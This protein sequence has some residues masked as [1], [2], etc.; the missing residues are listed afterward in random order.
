MPRESQED[1]IWDTA[2][3]LYRREASGRRGSQLKIWKRAQTSRPAYAF[4]SHT[5]LNKETVWLLLDCTIHCS[6]TF[7]AN[8]DCGSS[9]PI[10][11]NEAG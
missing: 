3:Q 10:N 11:L 5:L 7:S 6:S 9:T 4:P 8:P 1:V 2:E